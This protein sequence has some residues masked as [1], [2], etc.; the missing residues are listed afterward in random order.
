MRE[1]VLK[2]T[3]DYKMIKHMLKTKKRQ[4]KESITWLLIRT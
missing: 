3:M 2:L 1:V 4:L